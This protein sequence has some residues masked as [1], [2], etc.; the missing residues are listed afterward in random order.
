MMLNEILE[1]FQ[2]RLDEV[3]DNYTLTLEDNDPDGVH[4]MRVAI[5]RLKAFF[6]LVENVNDEF[7]A[8]ENFRN[9]RKIAKNTSGL[10]DSQVQ[11]ELLGKFNKKLNL[12]VSDFESYLKKMESENIE[13]F[14]NFSNKK[15]PVKKLDS[16]KKLLKK[17]LKNISPVWSETKAHGRFY[18]L[19]TDL[20]ILSSESDLREEILHKV[21]IQSKEIHYTLE[22]VQ[23]CFHIDENRTDFI[24]D[25]KKVHQIL[26]KWHDYD[27][28][29][30]YLD[31]FL[32]GYGNN[33][34]AATYKQLRKH[35][36]KQKAK[37]SGN[38][39]TVLDEFSKTASKF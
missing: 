29:L 24:R 5:K 38:F 26:G 34:S 28:N 23:K 1:Y 31:N 37:L 30:V 20:I 33:S 15:K 13:S 2:S 11:L 12:N 8:K 10:R 9:F 39:R 16:S 36:T 25:I 22:I 14:R 35:I 32:S 18:N 7:I 4:D 6:N 17:A 21:R 19:K 27:V 3:T